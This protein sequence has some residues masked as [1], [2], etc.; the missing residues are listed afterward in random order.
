M[1]Y[2]YADHYGLSLRCV[3]FLKSQVV[4]GYKSIVSFI[5]EL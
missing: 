5:Y 4:G 3:I 1:A 2:S